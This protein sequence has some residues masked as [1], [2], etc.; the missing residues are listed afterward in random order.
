M[1]NY[2]ASL[3]TLTNPTSADNLASPPH[4]NQHADANDIAE[5]LE[6]KLGTGASVPTTVGHVLTVTGAG[7]TAYRAPAVRLLG[8][9]T[10]NYNTAGIE[11]AAGTS[12]S[13]LTSGTVVLAVWAYVLTPFTGAAG[14]LWVGIDLAFGDSIQART[15]IEAVGPADI[16]A[17]GQSGPHLTSTLSVGVNSFPA[18][19][20]LNTDL[21][22]KLTKTSGSWTAGSAD[23]Y[24][25]IAEPA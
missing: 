19:C 11:T 7:A 24:A 17:R 4:A 5:A 12:L 18:R 10:V 20:S 9:F 1:A 6:V 13:A 25:L 23:I 22:A 15:N 2:P 8:P 21:G 16:Y 14:T 3:D